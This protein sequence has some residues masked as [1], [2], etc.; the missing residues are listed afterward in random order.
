MATAALTVRDAEPLRQCDDLDRRRLT[1][2]SGFGWVRLFIEC[3]LPYKVVP[4]EFWALDVSDDGE[5]SVALV[6]CPCGH[7]PSVELAAYP[8]KCE[9]ERWFF[10]AGTEVLSF[11][12]P[13]ANPDPEPVEPED[14]PDTA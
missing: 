6:A 1:R 5:A 14:D 7:Q 8:E 11:C 4:P 9:C 2:T 13:T 3:G 12:G 10:F